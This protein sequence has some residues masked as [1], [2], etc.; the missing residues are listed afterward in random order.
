MTL[1]L[2]TAQQS[3]DPYV[4]V[5]AAALRPDNTLAGLGFNG[6]PPGVDIDWADRD[7]R[8]PLIV[9]AE[10]NAL[11]HS[12]PAEL[13]GGLLASTHRPCAA[14]TSVIA[15]YGIRRVFYLFENDPRTYD[16]AELDRL[17]ETFSMQIQRIGG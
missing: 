15:S 17:A 13:S 3:Q 16:V 9:H 8:R 5:G 2:V 1:A 14:C 4:Q 11:R 12:T 6:P 7:R 10:Q